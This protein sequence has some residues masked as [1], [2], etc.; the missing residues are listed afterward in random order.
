MHQ[1]V[2]QTDE[3]DISV[4]PSLP[5]TPAYSRLVPLDEPVVHHAPDFHM[6][7]AQRL[8]DRWDNFFPFSVLHGW[9]PLMGL[10]FAVPSH[11]AATGDL[12]V[13]PGIPG[14]PAN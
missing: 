8:P 13:V 11:R 2:K 7:E 14:A 9:D 6:F 12:I 4:L 10:D 3:E 1:D 5:A